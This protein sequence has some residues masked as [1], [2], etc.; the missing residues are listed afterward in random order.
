MASY[1]EK[2]H[3]PPHSN[4]LKECN[5]AIDDASA[6]DIKWPKKSHCTSF[7][8]SWPKKFIGA[9]NDTIANGVKWPK[10]SCCISFQLSWTKE[11]HGAILCHWYHVMLRP[12]PMAPH[13]QKSHITP[14]FDHLDLINAVVS[15]TISLASCYANTGAM[16]I[17]WCWC[18]CQRNHMTRKLMWHLLLIILTQQMEW[19][20]WWHCLHHVTPTPASV[21]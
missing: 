7:Q 13:D 21:T 16:G 20:H 8:L 18:L 15:F 14:H 3:V 12:V 9:I 5:G 2:C 10:K 4:H 19:C 1:D 11:C 17:T 6:N